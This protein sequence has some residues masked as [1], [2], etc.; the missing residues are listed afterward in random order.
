MAERTQVFLKALALRPE[1]ALRK[2][3]RR[4]REQARILM[5]ESRCHA[6]WG[7]SGELANVYHPSEGLPYSSRYAPM[8]VLYTPSFVDPWE[9]RTDSI[10]HSKKALADNLR[11]DILR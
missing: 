11:V 8:I 2:K 6:D 5:V 10:G 3:C 9:P 7:L 1:P 4:F